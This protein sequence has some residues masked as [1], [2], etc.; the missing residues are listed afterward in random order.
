MSSAPLRFL[1]LPAE[2]R[3]MIYEDA[4]ITGDVHSLKIVPPLPIPYDWPRPVTNLLLSCRQIRN[5]AYDI[6]F[7]KNRFL[8]RA[9]VHQDKWN[10]GEAAILMHRQAKASIKDL[11]VVVD[12]HNYSPT[13][14][15][16][17]DFGV[18]Q[19][20]TSLERI[21]VVFIRNPRTVTTSRLV[22]WMRNIIERI[23][24]QCTIDTSCIFDQEQR[25]I[26]EC[27]GA[28]RITDED[29]VVEHR[30]TMGQ[31]G[32]EDAKFLMEVYDCERNDLV[33]GRLSGVPRDFPARR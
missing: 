5:E 20:L 14:V 26:S 4:L 10:T 18:F 19:T 16:D 11:F 17:V 28:N 9:E 15:R 8:V 32:T 6:L 7:D 2:I 33:Q 30:C 25:F 13:D 21:K 27:R 24:R 23:S 3:I 31:L 29:H 12:S 1:D 22:E